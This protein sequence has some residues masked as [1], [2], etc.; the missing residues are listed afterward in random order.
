MNNFFL[1]IHYFL[2]GFR[3]I[4]KP[5][6]RRFV[7]IPVS[8]NIVFFIGLFLVLR[9]FASELNGWIFTHLPGFLRWLSIIFWL[10]FFIS[11]F[12]VLIY[13]FVMMANIISAPFN[14][15]LAEKVEIYLTGQVLVKRSMLETIK[16]VPRMIGRQLAVLIYSLPRLLLLL[17][18]FFI[19]VIQLVAALL[20]FIFSAWLMAMTYT[21]YPSDN[22]RVSFRQLRD[23][24]RQRRLLA[25]GFGMSVL[26]VSMIPVLNFFVIPVAVAGATNLWIFQHKRG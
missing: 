13:F 11:F 9:H 12:L 17:I 20:W 22:H 1:G 25:L 21:D 16:D 24:L 7:I 3:L 18:L 4:A 8:L 2:S 6:V 26:M 19:P 10:L 5:G 15:L 14:G 23:W